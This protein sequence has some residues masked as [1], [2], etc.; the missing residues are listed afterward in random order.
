MVK[1]EQNSTIK[2]S[3]KGELIS[4]NSIGIT[5][6]DLKEGTEDV[7]KFEDLKDL[8]G[9]EITIAIQNKEIV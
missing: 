7:I 5:V 2:I 4:V 6:K 8:I 9:K 1:I 3:A